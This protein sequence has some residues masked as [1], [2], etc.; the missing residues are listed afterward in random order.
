M[1]IDPDDQVRLAG[2][3][4]T[5]LAPAE[6]RFLDAQLPQ[7]RTR[8]LTGDFSTGLALVNSIGNAADAADHHPDLDLRYGFLDV[9][10]SSHD[11][12]GVTRRDLRLAASIS[13]M[14]RAAGV[15]A[16][17][18]APQVVELGLDTWASPEKGY[19]ILPFWRAVLGYPGRGD[20]G[21]DVFDPTGRGPL[22]WFQATDEHEEPRQRFHLDICVPHDQVEARIAAAVEAGGLLV[23]DVGAPA[24]WVLADPQGNKACLC[25][26]QGRG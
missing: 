4:I 11:V 5:E 6:W 24:F 23:T 21:D 12:G 18:A 9:S 19:E 20:D 10:L 22:I 16:D 8:F 17:P 3:E 2:A 25:T 15:E 1:A 7:L 26:W 14:A 13:E